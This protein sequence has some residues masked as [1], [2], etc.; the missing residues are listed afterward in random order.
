M[1]AEQAKAK[2]TKCAEAAAAKLAGEAEEYFT[3]VKK[4][5]ANQSGIFPSGADESDLLW[6]YKVT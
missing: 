4:A 5:V 3:L 6:I 2:N 1:T